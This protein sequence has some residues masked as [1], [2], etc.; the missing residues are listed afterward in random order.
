M[1]AA[2]APV[3]PLTPSEALQLHKVDWRMRFS[4]VGQL[5]R[6]GSYK[7]KT[8]KLDQP[9]ITMLTLGGSPFLNITNENALIGLRQGG[10]FVVE[11][12]L[13][14]SGKAFSLGGVDSLRPFIPA[15]QQ[16]KPI[17]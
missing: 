11:G 14:A 12:D 10:E 8:T 6:I 13:I 4:I 16:P 3:Q 7:D 9:Y 5:V 15:I 2:T 17:K 1:T